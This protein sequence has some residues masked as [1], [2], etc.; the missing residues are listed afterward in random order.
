MGEFEGVQVLYPLDQPP[1]RFENHSEGSWEASDRYIRIEL[2]SRAST[3]LYDNL[4]ALIGYD[5][6]QEMY[7]MWFFARSLTE[8]MY[9]TGNFVDGSLIMV[10]EPSPM[11]SGVQKLR[12]SFTAF[13]DDEYDILGEIWTLDGWQ[14]YS[15]SRMQRSR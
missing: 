15:C 4:L 2:F 1:I 12:Y 13:G 8:P 5:E 9:L 7:R 3:S 14:R 11:A 6:R 10:S